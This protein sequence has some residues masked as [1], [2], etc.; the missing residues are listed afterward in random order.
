MKARGPSAEQADRFRAALYRLSGG[1]PGRIGVAVSGG[2][3]SLALLLLVAAVHSEGAEAAT[4]D[5]GL[6]A[7]SATE[8]DY[9]REVC[10]GLGIPHRVLRPAAPISGNLQ[11]AARE[12]RYALLEAWR[13]GQGLDWILT[14]HHADDQAETLLMRLNRG[15]GIG[16]LSGIRAANGRVLRPLLEW[17]H[18]EL[19]GLVEAAGVEAIADPSNA[20]ERFDRARLR[21]QLAKA[22]WIDV[23]AFARSA[24]A[25]AEAQ[26]ALDWTADQLFEERARAEPGGLSI[27]PSCLPAELVRR[28]V[29]RALRCIAGDADPRGEELSR[30]IATLEQGGTATLT[31]AK[32]VGG[33]VWRFSPAPAR[34]GS[35]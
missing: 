26:D 19:T 20:D 13:A 34:R 22:D 4:V 12:A 30:L 29:L 18:A 35:G 32:A 11:S 17:R 7:E 25:V 23:S 27:D 33:A 6:R 9:V 15:S 8:A 31:G 16:G 1:A 14:A 28:L 24:A 10:A 21:A 5:H 3:D 2:P